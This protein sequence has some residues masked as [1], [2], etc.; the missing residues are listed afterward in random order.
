MNRLNQ[1][2]NPTGIGAACVSDESSAGKY[3]A[4][5]ARYRHKG[6]NTGAIYA[7]CNVTNPLDDG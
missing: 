6:S 3:E 1:V 5:A 4:S 7:R 2:M